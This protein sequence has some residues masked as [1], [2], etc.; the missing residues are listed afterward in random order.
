MF[1][2]DIEL[3][4]SLKNA[5]PNYNFDT[6][7]HELLAQLKAAHK[8]ATELIQLRKLENKA[9]YDK[10]KHTELKLKRND[11]VLLYSGKREGKFDLN[12]T[13]PYRVSEIISPA[14]T[15]I[16]IKNKIGLV[17]NDKLKLATADYGDKTPPLLDP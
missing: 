15:E 6:Y 12:Y 11:L 1:G 7:Q 8:R 14:I 17:H 16:K 3:P 2:F 5:R 4:I 10:Q 13:G 9:S